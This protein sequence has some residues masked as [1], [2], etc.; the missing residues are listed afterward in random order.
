MSETPVIR[1]VIAD[2]NRPFRRGVRLRLEHAD[3]IVVVGEAANGRDA[4]AGALSEHA[5][6][7]LMDLEMPE[8]NGIDATRAIV[9]TSHGKTRVIVLTSHGE[10]HLVMRALGNGAAGYLLKTH[11]SAQ[12]VEAIRAAHRGDALVSTHVTG[13]VLREIVDRR[14]TPADR[15]KLASLSPT[16]SRVVRL[17]SEGI[18]SNEQLAAQLVVSVNTI[19][20]HIQSSLR[21]V[22]VADR[23]QLALWGVRV[24]AELTPRPDGRF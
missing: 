13:P 19:R 5:D 12:L 17:L 22:D 18:T 7:V 23:T 10:D 1:V 9:E 16:E 14:L 8:M 2:D 11:D 20:T 24:G 15:E 3:G 4:L 21:K 6:V